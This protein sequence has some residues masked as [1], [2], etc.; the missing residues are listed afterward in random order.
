MERNVQIGKVSMDYFINA[1]AQ[2]GGRSPERPDQPRPGAPKML[3]D[4]HM[5]DKMN[6]SNSQTLYFPLLHRI[7]LRLHSTL[8]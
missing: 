1:G 7:G 8:L 3:G 6:F 4:K 2:N 5:Q